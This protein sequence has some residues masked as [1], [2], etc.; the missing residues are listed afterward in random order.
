MGFGLCLGVGTGKLVGWCTAPPGSVFGSTA[1]QRRRCF[2]LLRSAGDVWACV[3][4]ANWWRRQRGGVPLVGYQALCRELAAA[5]PGTFGELDSVGARS[6]LRR[7]SDAWFSAAKR[8]KAGNV[9]VRF[10]R[11]RRRLMP[12]R[13]YHGTFAVDGRQVRLPTA[14]GCGPLWLR[15]DRDIRYPAERVRSVTLLA[16]GGRLWSHNASSWSSAG[17]RLLRAYK[18]PSLLPQLLAAIR[19]VLDPGREQRARTGRNRPRLFV[20]SALSR[21]P[22]GSQS[23]R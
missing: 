4:E 9:D 10:P 11:R 23:V 3:L 18:L 14:A 5:G 6:V 1:A 20:L 16:E 15:L 13:F 7:Y 21:G 12:V 17:S 22:A 19:L 8:R 2:G